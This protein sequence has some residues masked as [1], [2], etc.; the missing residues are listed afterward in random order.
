MYNLQTESYVEPNLRSNIVWPIDYLNIMDSHRHNVLPSLKLKR[1]S[2]VP[3]QLLT[4]GSDENS[5]DF[6]WKQ[7]AHKSGN[8]LTVKTLSLLFQSKFRRPSGIY[9][10]VRLSDNNCPE[11]WMSIEHLSSIS[12]GQSSPKVNIKDL[13]RNFNE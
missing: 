13:N 10:R 3:E 5:A 12:L 11:L 8:H 7:R 1:Y 4:R 6:L 2:V 9:S